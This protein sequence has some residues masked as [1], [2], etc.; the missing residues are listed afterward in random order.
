MGHGDP[1]SQWDRIVPFLLLIIALSSP[2]LINLG[3]SSI[4]QGVL[5]LSCPQTLE[6]QQLLYIT[7]FTGLS[8]C[9]TSHLPNSEHLK[10]RGLE[11]G[12]WWGPRLRDLRKVT[13]S[14]E[15][16]TKMCLKL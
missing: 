10:V 12:R 16:S 7:K 4:S 15:E 2:Q 1:G 13:S 11:A 6:G 5:E 14:L 9:T 3:P 8:N